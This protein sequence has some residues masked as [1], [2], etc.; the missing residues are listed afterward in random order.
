MDAALPVLRLI[1]VGAGG[2]IAHNPGAAAAALPRR[3]ARRH[4]T[5]QSLDQQGGSKHQ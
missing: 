2:V 5:R 3:H 4:G 1:E